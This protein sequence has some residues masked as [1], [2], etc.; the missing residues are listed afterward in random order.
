MKKLNNKQLLALTSG[1]YHDGNGLYITISRQGSGKWSFRY[2]INQK[3][4][5]MGLGKFP[6]VS[7][8]EGRLQSLNNKQLLAKKIDPI[9]DKNRVEV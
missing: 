1:K 4:R 3:S 7:L 5:E 9:D 2:R 8:A 6:E